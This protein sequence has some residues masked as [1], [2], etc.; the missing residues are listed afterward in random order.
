MY[1]NSAV[2]RARNRSPTPT[3]DDNSYFSED[4]Y[5]R[6]KIPENKKVKA[7]QPIAKN[8][9]KKKEKKKKRGVQQSLIGACM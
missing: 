6:G 3:S 4:N 9:N 1:N 7:P 8:K 2:D 5:G